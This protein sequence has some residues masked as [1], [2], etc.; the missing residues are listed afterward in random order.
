MEGDRPKDI[1]LRSCST[2]NLGI[3]MVDDQKGGAGLNMAE[4]DAKIRVARLQL[5]NDF[6]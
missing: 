6:S 4:L 3:A 2:L 5:V 1:P